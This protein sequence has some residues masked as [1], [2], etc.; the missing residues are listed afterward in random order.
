MNVPTMNTELARRNM[1]DCQIRPWE[2]LETRVLDAFAAVPRDQFVPNAYRSL[3]YADFTIPL[4]HGETMMAP[5][6]EGRMLQA[7]A[8]KPSD[9]ALEIGTGSGFVAALLGQ[10]SQQVVSIDIHDQFVRDARERLRIAAIANVEVRVADGA[11]G[12]LVDGPY[13]VVAVTGSL[14]FFEPRLLDMLTI[15]GRMFVVI[16]S[17]PAMDAVLITKLSDRKWSQQPLFETV[18]TPLRNAP[19]RETFQ[20]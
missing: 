19:R 16:G 9:R 14:G 18:L 2:V 7:L 3:A 8:T 1:I 4:G 6:V 10:L 20:F 11:T 13:D 17:A 15:G 5:R 12:Y